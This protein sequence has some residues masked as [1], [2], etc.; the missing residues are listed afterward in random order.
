MSSLVPNAN[1]RMNIAKGECTNEAE[2]DVAMWESTTNLK[3]VSLAEIM[4]TNLKK[5]CG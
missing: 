4:D 2:R 3:V 5:R 1:L